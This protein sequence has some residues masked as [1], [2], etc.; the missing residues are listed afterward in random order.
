MLTRKEST[1][2]EIPNGALLRPCCLLSRCSGW[3]GAR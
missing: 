3:A 1:E 2:M